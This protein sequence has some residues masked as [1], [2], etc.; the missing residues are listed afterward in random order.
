[1]E[2]H[3]LPNELSDFR[4]VAEETIQLAGTL[5]LLWRVLA[6]P[7][8]GSIRPLPDKLPLPE[9]LWKPPH[10]AY[11]ASATPAAT[12]CLETDGR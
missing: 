6:R 11:K 7:H 3:P 5:K 8:D 12:I 10:R 4:R 9:L 1:M 2:W